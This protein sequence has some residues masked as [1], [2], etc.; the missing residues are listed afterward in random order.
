MATWH[1]ALAISVGL[2]PSVRSL[3]L[4]D[5]L[6]ESKR[7]Y[8]K[9][10]AGEEN[11]ISLIQYDWASA[12]AATML[13][14]ILIPEVLGYHV[15]KDTQA[16]VSIFEG[17][18]KLAGCSSANCSVTMRPQH[19]ALETWLAEAITLFQEFEE[20]HAARA[21]ED[22]GSMG[23]NGD[24]YLFVKGS[25]RDQAYSDAG[26]AL[27]FYKSYNTTFHFPQKYFDRLES[28]DR[29]HFF[30]C[31]LEGLEFR[32][33]LR[34]RDYVRWTGDLDGVIELG[35]GQYVARCAD[36]YF[37]LS[38]SCRQNSSTC[39][40]L[41][42][43]GNGW[44]VDAMMQ[45][46]AA[47]GFP[48]AIGIAKDWG[49]FVATVWSTKALFYWW[50]PD[51]TFL[52]L[53]PSYIVLPPHSPS[54]WAQGNLRTAGNQ[55]YI[56]KLVSPILRTAAPSVRQFLQNFKLELGDMTQLLSEAANG[57]SMYDV[58]CEW[59]LA[60]RERWAKWVPVDTN[61][62][63]GFGLADARNEHVALRA[64][65]TGCAL[66]GPGMFSEA[67]VDDFGET[68]RCVPC[69]AGSHQDSS[70][71]A[72]CA[73]CEPGTVALF[74]GA[75]TCAKCDLGSYA[76]S[77]GMTACDQCGNDTMWT[78]SRS[79]LVRGQSTWLQ[80]EG[81]TSENDCHC[82]EGYFL[83]R[84]Q[85]KVCIEGSRCAGS[86]ALELLPG[87]F[88]YQEEPGMVYKCFGQPERCPGGPPG[89]CAA[90]RDPTSIGCSQCLDQLQPK[91]GECQ[92][93]T[94]GDYLLLVVFGSMVIIS[95][96]GLHVLLVISDQSNGNQRSA[97]FTA[98][99][100][101]GQ[102]VTCAQLFGIMQQLQINWAEP[103]QVLLDIFDVISLDALLSS[104]NVLGCVTRVTPELEYLIRSLLLPFFFLVGPI[105]AHVNVVYIM[106]K[107]GRGRDLKLSL[108][109]KTLG[110]FSL[111][112]FITLCSSFLKPFR[113]NLHPNGL[114][115][116]QDSHSVLCDFSGSH[117]SLCL[118]GGVVCL[119][120]LSYLAI[121]I[122]V[123]LIE[124]PKRMVAADVHFVRACSFLVMR[125]NPGQEIFTVLF[126]LRNVLI[127]MAPL[128]PSASGSLFLMAFLLVVSFGSVAYCKP[129]RSVLGTQVDMVVHMA[130]L[131]ILQMGALA[132]TDVQEQV[133]MIICTACAACMIVT[134]IWA[135]AQSAARHILSKLHKRFH[136][137]LCHHKASTAS[138]ARL[139]KME[140]LHRG[141]SFTAFL[142]SDNLTDLTQLFAYVSHDVKTLVVLGSSRIL[143]RKWCMGEMVVARLEKVDTVL[144]SFPGFEL[145]DEQFIQRYQKLIPD[146][147]DFASYGF[148]ML[149]VKDTLHWLSTVKTL[150]VS[151]DFSWDGLNYIINQL[152]NTYVKLPVSS[153]K[154]DCYI[155]ADPVNMEAISTGYILAK[156]I[157]PMI[158]GSR[159]SLP[160]VLSSS[161]HHLPHAGH[162]QDKMH[163]ILVCTGGCLSS[164]Q[165]A[166]W[167]MQA[168]MSSQVRFMAN[169][170]VAPVI[171]DDYFQIPSPLNIRQ[172]IGQPSLQHLDRS[173]Y[174]HVL[175]AIFLEIALPFMPGS[176]SAD[177]LT[178]RATQIMSRLEPGAS[179]TLSSRL[180]MVQAEMG[181]GLWSGIESSEEPDEDS[182]SNNARG[183]WTLTPGR[184]PSEIVDT[185]PAQ[186][187]EY[188]NMLNS[189]TVSRAF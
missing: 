66:C 189:E 86:N 184:Y 185:E 10:S 2:A 167:I 33:A 112:F 119:L 131:L 64:V 151:Q 28:F 165:L 69:P 172:L 15:V 144:L 163:V 176:A 117:L 134:I 89:I 138:W 186:L 77:S 162:G 153:E 92:A 99:L 52:P 63:A 173:A 109:W 150:P 116:L 183:S 26:L 68:Y 98:A 51:A 147:G 141:P 161:S 111:I 107:A 90:G 12:D 24:H 143:T 122:W 113:C 58:A 25:I 80:L 17:V 95:T 65:A 55:N 32:N 181:E 9:D 129:W 156:L 180:V 87:F 170:F 79:L 132:V 157:T 13:A 135:A 88:A 159:E 3:C 83:H 27:D 130:L 118:I 46:S 123:I 44:I 50:M 5:G 81:A 171:S 14:E 177:D 11:P 82:A 67:L 30:R 74:A 6:A 36:D 85:C 103:F 178:V 38:P 149:E 1:L 148:G 16:T 114:R 140:L 179:T 100:S 104:I 91:G 188:L 154:T 168:M 75:V 22:L 142:D 20:N 35:P 96:G 39:I 125:F 21:P 127:V 57:R 115:T 34:M 94:G 93:C 45:W 41:L 61:C 54:E 101:I 72:S 155:L 42:A 43:A 105:L 120:P 37:W 19:V 71:Q 136:F 164:P 59:V 126:L 60:N 128:L 56:T 174:A 40:P 110:L 166:Q 47:Y 152:T 102:L 169:C 62:I 108:L 8:L 182:V 31:D 53:D 18:L 139:L 121:S 133:T 145:P 97:L 29:R 187:Q 137:F 73:L 106:W 23:Y 76:N 158:M 160:V 84:N 78:T 175:N 7:L 70:G 124:L 146:I 4:R 49:T 48:V